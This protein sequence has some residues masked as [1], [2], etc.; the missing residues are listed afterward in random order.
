MMY[1][2]DEDTGL[3]ELIAAELKRGYDSEL[4]PEQSEWL[5]ASEAPHPSLRMASLKIG[6]PSRVSWNTAPML[7]KKTLHA[8]N[9][10]GAA[11][12]YPQI[13]AISLQT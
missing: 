13:L 12:R 10:V 9:I 3:V 4:R 8:E 6:M 1:R 7:S 5:D 2:R 11:V